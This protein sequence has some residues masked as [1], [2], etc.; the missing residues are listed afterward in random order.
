[1]R[2][3][4]RVNS[5]EFSQLTG[6]DDEGCGVGKAHQDGIRK[7]IDHETEPEKPQE[8]LN[9]SYQKGQ[10]NSQPDIIGASG[11][12]D[13]LKGSGGHQGDNGYRPG[14]QLTA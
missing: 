6:G 5:Q 8:K 11:Y 7:K 4:F 3:L 12:G 13:G 9:P 1:M 14:G 2:A 10:E